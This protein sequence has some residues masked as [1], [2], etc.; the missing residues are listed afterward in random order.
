[1]GGV[2][3]LAERREDR[4]L[5]G[6]AGPR[7]ASTF[8]FDLACPHTYLAADRVERLLGGVVWRPAFA[9]A[10]HR[11]DPW[12]DAASRE[13]LRQDVQRR[14]AVLRMPLVWPDGAPRPA[15]AVMRAAAFATE[16]GR[17]GPFA[18]AASRLAYCGGFDL[19]DP[20]VLA[21]AAAA[22]GIG[23]R[24]CL[25]AARDLSRDEQLT[26]AGRRLLAAG[27]D[28]LPAVQVGRAVICGE[29]RLGEAAA[30]ADSRPSGQRVHQR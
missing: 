20:E 10:L 23:L 5:A 8:F 25:R 3:S 19:D 29:E 28:R 13:Q 12:R 21:E 27:A 1:M 4:R 15:R 2:I 9:D 16:Q 18:L 11:A 26:K 24:E 7:A 30:W 17:G 22:A 14:A 6:P